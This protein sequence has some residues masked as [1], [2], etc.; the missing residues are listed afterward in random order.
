MFYAN[1]SMLGIG[2]SHA[3]AN[4]LSAVAPTLGDPK[5]FQAETLCDSGVRE[6]VDGVGLSVYKALAEIK[7]GHWTDV[8]GR[9]FCVG[10]AHAY[11]EARARAYGPS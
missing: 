7:D 8:A 11:G 9:S 3:A 6:P 1:C 4:L 2:H 5:S 10:V